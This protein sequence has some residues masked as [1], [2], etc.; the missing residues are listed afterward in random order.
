MKNP[1]GPSSELVL[2][3]RS[4]PMQS[5]CKLEPL[6]LKE[7]FQVWPGDRQIE[8]ERER[9]RVSGPGGPDAAWGWLDAFG[10]EQPS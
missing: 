5:G 2:E 6:P 1:G 8:I 7:C 4:E 10:W 3:L 9:E